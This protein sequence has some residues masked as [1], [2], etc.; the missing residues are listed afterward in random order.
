MKFLN[1]FRGKYLNYF[2]GFT[3]NDLDHHLLKLFIEGE[4][5]SSIEKS[6]QSFQLFQLLFR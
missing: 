4:L 6:R 3:V 5:E 1:F 2:I